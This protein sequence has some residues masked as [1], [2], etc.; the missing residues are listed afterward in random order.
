MMNEIEV[1][2]RFLNFLPNIIGAA[3]IVLLGVIIGM[4]LGYVV[5]RII[6]AAKL[7][8]FLDSTKFSE[9]LK[10]AGIKT[11]I[12][13]TL[14]QF[15]RYAVILISF[16]PAATI[17][18]LSRVEQFIEGLTYLATVLG[19]AVFVVV[20]L[21]II[22]VIAKVVWA[23]LESVGLTLAKMVSMAI[24]WVLYLFIL[25][26]AMF[27]LGVPREFIVIMFIGVTASLAIASG[28]SFGL[29]SKDHADDLI[30]RIRSEFKQ[31]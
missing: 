12:S 31:K 18:S 27:A 22:D 3:I 17:L 9:T 19:V 8:S 7:Q 4:I 15:V 28:L 11:D 10:K 24:R 25:I 2:E 1:W 30:K 26:A 20:A 21:V 5:T 13:E 16:L 14:G 29:G 6:Q 23:A